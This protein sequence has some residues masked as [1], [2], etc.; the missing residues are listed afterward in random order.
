MGVSHTSL[1]AS[2]VVA[3]QQ[4]RSL[5][6]QQQ[7]HGICMAQGSLLYAGRFACSSTAGASQGAG[8]SGQAEAY[9]CAKVNRSLYARSAI[10]EYLGTFIAD[11]DEGG[12]RQGTQWLLWKYESDTTLAEACQVCRAALWCFTSCCSLLCCCLCHHLRCMDAASRHGQ[13][14]R[15]AEAAARCCCLAVP[16]SVSGLP[17][18]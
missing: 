18:A 12:F 3:A 15:K 2:A 8:E 10:A 13:D 1:H 5:Q 9:M 16:S 17:G 7:I 14:A 11:A 4:W 6:L